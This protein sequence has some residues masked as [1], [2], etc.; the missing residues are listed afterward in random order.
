MTDTTP[1]RPVGYDV[2]YFLKKFEAIPEA[3]WTVDVY[4]K[5]DTGQFCALGHCGI[6]YNGVSNTPEA[7]AFR[8]LVEAYS[9]RHLPRDR[10]A[11]IAS[12]NDGED[13]RYDQPTPRQRILALLRDI[14]A[15]S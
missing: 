1:T 14:K 5:P 9:Q 11:R 12:V 8:D 4:E 15:A 10:C 3:R 6:N 2:D 7:Q 13:D